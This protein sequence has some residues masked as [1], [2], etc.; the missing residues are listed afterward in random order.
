MQLLEQ[1][2]AA[3]GEGNVEAQA[4]VDRRKAAESLRGQGMPQGARKKQLF[5]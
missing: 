4:L 5:R 1:V 2:A 3:A